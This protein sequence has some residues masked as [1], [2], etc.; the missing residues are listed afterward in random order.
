MLSYS[1]M[2]TITIPQK[3]AQKGDLVLLSREEYDKLLLFRLKNIREVE[4]TPV[5]RKALLRAR[6]NV[7]RGKFL[8]IHGLKAKLGSKN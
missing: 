3:I 2:N 5:Q 4:L 6:K 1:H 8:T 7:S